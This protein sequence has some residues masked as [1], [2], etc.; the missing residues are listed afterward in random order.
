MSVS[1]LEVPPNE[2]GFLVPGDRGSV[3]MKGTQYLGFARE[4]LR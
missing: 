2:Y 3:T 1:S 4:I